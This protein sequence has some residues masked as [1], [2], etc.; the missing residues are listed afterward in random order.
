MN[1]ILALKVY[2][3]VGLISGIILCICAYYKSQDGQEIGEILAG[4]GLC[5][6][7]WPIIWAWAFTELMKVKIPR[8]TK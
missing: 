2:G 5:V 4:M 7:I 1:E 6:L 3:I 8:R